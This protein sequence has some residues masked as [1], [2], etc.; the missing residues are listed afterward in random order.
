MCCVLLQRVQE[1]HDALDSYHD[2]D[3]DD[4]HN[5]F[6]ALSEQEP[7]S[8]LY[9]VYLERIETLRDAILPGDWDGSFTHTSK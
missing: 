2:K 6:A 9:K 5:R 1:Y 8:L 4:A 7:D 3:W